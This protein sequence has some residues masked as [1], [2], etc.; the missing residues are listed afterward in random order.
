MAK[1]FDPRTVLK[2]LSKPLLRELF[3]KRGELLD[4]PWDDVKENND[5]DAIYNAWQQLPEDRRQQVQIILQDLVEMADDRGIRAFVQDLKDHCPDR[6]WQFTSCVSRPNKALWFYLNFPERF[7][8]VAL[9]ARA[10]ALSNGRYA[11]RRNS[12]PRKSLQVTPQ[13]LGSLEGA[14]CGYFWPQEMRGEHCNVVHHTR[15]DGTHYFFAYLDN[16]PDM[17][18][19]FGRDGQMKPQ[20]ERYAFSVVFASCPQDGALELIAR[21]GK[22]VQYE[23]QKAFCS[24]VYGLEVEPADEARPVYCLQKVLD[25]NFTYPTAVTDCVQRARLARVRLAPIPKTSDIAYVDMRFKSKV[26]RVQ[27]LETMHRVMR[28]F[29]L[30]PEQVLVTRATFQLVFITNALGGT[31]TMTFTVAL[32]SYCDLKNKPEDVRIV[33]QRCLNLWEMDN[34]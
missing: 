29:D 10:D 23:L 28:D 9:F 22:S 5:V 31:R 7:D 24:S 34:G 25:P 21:G 27:S 19:V 33:G 6:V 13:M 2:Q 17:R 16:W 20:S 4:L 12:L 26:T 11:V 1:Q 32:P 30:R 15:A 14:L 18:L 8:R 3:A